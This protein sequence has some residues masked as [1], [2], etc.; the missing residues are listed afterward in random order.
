MPS[1]EDL[2]EARR[3]MEGIMAL[4]AL[5]DSCEPDRK[6][7]IRREIESK[8]AKASDLSSVP[9]DHILTKA[10]R[11]HHERLQRMGKER[12]DQ[13]SKNPTMPHRA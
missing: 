3:I 13:I 7:A 11:D 8:A 6:D 12:F 9:K 1:D 2:Q 4:V 5:M 10:Y